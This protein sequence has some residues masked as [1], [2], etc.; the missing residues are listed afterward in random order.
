MIGFDSGVGG[1]T[2]LPALRRRMPDGDFVHVGDTARAPYGRKPANV[3][4]G[5]A[6]EMA[7]F[8][9]GRGVD[10]IVVAC[11]TASAV[12]L[13]ELKRRCAVPV[14]SSS[15]L[16]FP[17]GVIERGDV[18]TGMIDGYWGLLKSG[19]IGTDHQISVKHLMRYLSEFRFKWNHRK[20]QNVLVW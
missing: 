20:A 2:V 17:L 10:G 7:D 1:L 9:S 11:S 4:A 5:F 13:P 3:V 15:V 14:S 16:A 6:C 12:A 8:L 18:H 19:V